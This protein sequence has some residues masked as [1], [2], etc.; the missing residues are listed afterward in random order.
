MAVK[1]WVAVGGTLAALAA[2]GL[3]GGFFIP[4]L[5]SPG[6]RGGANVREAGSPG[7]ASLDAA[8]SAASASLGAG[9]SDSGADLTAMSG[10][11]SPDLESAISHG[12]G[13]EVPAPTAASSLKVAPPSG[14]N[15]SQQSG[16]PSDVHAW[17]E[18]L[19]QT[20]AA[21]S[22]LAQR[23]IT[24]AMTSLAKIQAE[25]MTSAMDTDAS[26]DPTASLRSQAS[27]LTTRL[28]EAWV[29]LKQQF[30][31]VAAPA[32]CSA[33]KS[34]YDDT[35]FATGQ[36]MVELLSAIEAAAHN[37]QA[38]L[39]ALRGMQGTSGSRI[40]SHASATD[41]EVARICARYATPKWFSIAKDL[42]DASLLSKIGID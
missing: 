6:E 19:R 27:G 42:G 37:P 3:A 10:A 32:E 22:A 18:H 8:A 14:T 24:E 7:S 11:S 39:T 4:K 20:E 30:D 5:A 38:A 34:D 40:D 2:I 28:R 21:R 12:V 29:S 26:D 23:Q 31:S 13:L 36:M 25:K 1:K 15:L 41:D 17:L 35:I 16:M 9:A 33:A